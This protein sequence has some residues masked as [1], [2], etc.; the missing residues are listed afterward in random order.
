ME[1]SFIIRSV[2]NEEDANT[3]V[4][5]PL[6]DVGIQNKIIWHFSENGRY[7]VESGCKIAINMNDNAESSSL[8]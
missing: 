5:L 6:L 1:W 7:K 2:F 8:K 3:I 4:K